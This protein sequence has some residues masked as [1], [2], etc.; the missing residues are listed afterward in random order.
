MVER[1]INM[2]LEEIKKENTDYFDKILN[3][4][5]IKDEENN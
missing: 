3:F 5:Y 2:S 1:L 4:E